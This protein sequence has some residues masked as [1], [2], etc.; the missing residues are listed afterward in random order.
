MDKRKN[1]NNRK[2]EKKTR[3]NKEAQ[4]DNCSETKIKKKRKKI[5]MM[6]RTGKVES[7]KTCKRKDRKGRE[8]ELKS[9]KTVYKEKNTMQR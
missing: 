1:Y 9:T 3:I 5:K 8:K 6:I 7:T 4:K 2:E